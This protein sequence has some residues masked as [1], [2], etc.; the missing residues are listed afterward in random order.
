MQTVVIFDP[1]T[2]LEDAIAQ[3]ERMRPSSGVPVGTNASTAP[4]PVVPTPVAPEADVVRMHKAM[5]ANESRRFLEAL[6]SDGLTFAEL[7]ARMLRPDGTR[8]ENKSMRAIHRNVRRQERTLLKRGVI[9]E[10][11]V[12]GSFANYDADRAGR[13]FLN[14][15]ALAA[16][17]AHLGR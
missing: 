4:A 11:V 2:E 15:D 1:R 12:Q 6:T 10:P 3:L 8:R 5:A 7:A 9:Q 14:P 17:D 16:L 13:Y